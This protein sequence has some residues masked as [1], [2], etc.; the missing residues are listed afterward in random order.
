M[1]KKTQKPT[2]AQPYQHSPKQQQQKPMTPPVYAN[3]DA[4]DSSFQNSRYSHNQQQQFGFPSVLSSSPSTWSVN[5]N[6]N[7]DDELYVTVL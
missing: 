2:I 3:Q 4:L 7:Y 6:D 5:S 1:S